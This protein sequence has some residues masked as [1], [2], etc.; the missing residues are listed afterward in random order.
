MN[1]QG[2][3]QVA[4]TVDA[5]EAGMAFKKWLENE[6]DLGKAV[7]AGISWEFGKYSR[8]F[9]ATL[10]DENHHMVGYYLIRSDGSIVRLES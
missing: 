1:I 5:V 10:A 6:S 7:I 3:I 9:I 2:S 8:G 4:G